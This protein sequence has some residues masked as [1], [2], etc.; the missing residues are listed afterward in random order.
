MGCV[1]GWFL[2]KLTCEGRGFLLFREID[3]W[4]AWLVGFR[5]RAIAFPKS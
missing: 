5:E 3:L 1:V 2:E 4:G